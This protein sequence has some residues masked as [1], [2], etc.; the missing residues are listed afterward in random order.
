MSDA[1]YLVTDP[2]GQFALLVG[3]AAFVFA[4]GE[5]K[6]FARFF[7]IVPPL[8]FCYFLPMICTTLGII[9]AESIVYRMMI[10]IMLPAV[11]LLLLLSADI[12]GIIRL[13]P[14]AI[15]VMLA[16]TAGVMLGALYGVIVFGHLLPDGGWLPLAAL[17]GSWSGG[18]SNMFAVATALEVP[19][20]LM[21]PVILLDPI[22]VYS[23]L[24]MLLA[25]SKSQEAWARLNNVNP[26][27]ERALHAQAESASNE[28]VHAPTTG[29]L[30]VIV[31]MAISLG[32]LMMAFGSTLHGWLEPLRQM[33]PMVSVLTGATLGIL[34]VTSL[35]IILSFTRVGQLERFG[36][37]RIGYGML[38]LM[39]PAFGAQADL[40]VLGAAMGFAAVALTMV[41]FHAAFILLA[42][43]LLRAPLFFGAVGSQANFG[44]PAS[45]SIVAAA[46]SPALAPVGI[47]LGIFGGVLG[48]Y[49][50]LA[51]GALLKAI[52][53]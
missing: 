38:F 15:V 53:G 8:V 18:S 19:Q 34:L 31:G 37:S 13:G 43:R 42:M 29:I 33:A 46:Y 44:G 4:L 27:L 45:A 10:S 9:P 22:I 47:L 40:R 1:P 23:W 6:A 48:T 36:A 49:V 39:L 16:G 24:G 21:A 50:G 12:P 5:V 32:A 17:A 14:V 52:A 25:F 30:I 41:A 2:V 28:T 26:A 20:P 35:G 3:L 11:L 51:T 7:G